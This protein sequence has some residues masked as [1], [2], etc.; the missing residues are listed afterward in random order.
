M[1]ILKFPEISKLLLAVSGGIDSMVMLDVLKKEEKYDLSVITVNHNIRSEGKSD[2]LFVKSQC[3]RL[4]VSCIIESIDV[5]LFAKENSLSIETAARILR[6][7]AIEKHSDRYD[8]VCFAHHANDQAETLLMHIMRGSGSNGLTAM[9]RLSGKKARPL[10]FVTRREIEDYAKRHGIDFVEDET[11][12]DTAYRRNFVRHKILPLMEECY[13]GTTTALCRLAEKTAVD[14]DYFDGIIKAL[15]ITHKENKVF[16]ERSVFNALHP[17]IKTRAVFKMLEAVSLRVNAEEKHVDAIISLASGQSGKK[18]NLHDGGIAYTEFDKLVIAKN[19]GKTK[20]DN[21]NSKL[22]ADNQALNAN[23]ESLKNNTNNFL[24]INDAF[25][26]CQEEIPFRMLIENKTVIA[27][28]FT[29]TIS[30]EPFSY[31]EQ[32]V[33]QKREASTESGF[34]DN[35]K[36]DTIIK[37]DE[38]KIDRILKFDLSSLPEDCV[39][40]TR[41]EGDVFTKF[42][43]K[44]KKLKDFFIERKIPADK[45]DKLPIIAQRNTVFIVCGVEI[46]EKLRITEETTAVRYLSIS[47]TLK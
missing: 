43:G 34:H 28:A 45:R 26:C 16:I 46:S 33:A 38:A 14:R 1:N 21:I 20:T 40:R 22:K 32:I 39:I 6:H 23:N 10:L 8:F 25:V 42:G 19:N 13:E 11:N 5:P 35:V 24:R 7:E 3:E 37:A 36:T 31:K 17:A 41:K 44:T 47:Q 18:L 15:K 4:G 12:N 30:K 9:S 2:A 27:G 29:L